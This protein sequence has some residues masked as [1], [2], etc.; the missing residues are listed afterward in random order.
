MDKTSQRGYSA[1]VIIIIALLL[2]AVP[3]FYFT[4]TKNLSLFSSVDVQGASSVGNI[5]AQPGFSVSIISDSETWDLVEY[6]CKDLKECT[7]SLT[8][9]RRL[10]TVSG[11]KTDLH[12]VVVTSASEWDSYDYVKYFVRSGWYSQNKM[13]RVANLGDVPG[14]QVRTIS[15]GAVSYEV[16]ISPT[17]DLRNNFY[18]SAVFSDR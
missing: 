5:N 15:D 6:L 4:R 13:F 8:S 2:L 11:G 14:S 18:S 7:A 17:K 12:E 9:G 16:V 3:V 10:G 1:P